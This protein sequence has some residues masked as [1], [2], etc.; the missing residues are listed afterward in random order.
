LKLRSITKCANMKMRFIRALAFAGQRRPAL[1]AKSSP[2]PGRRI[3]LGDL[4]LINDICVALEGHEDRDRR[5]AM[6]AATFAV[7]PH[8][9]FRLT[10]GHEAYG[11]TQAAAF[12]LI[13]H[14]A[15]LSASKFALHGI[16]D[17]RETRLPPVPLQC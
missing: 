3:E 16:K 13:A 14:A 10:R 2:S 17:P 12:E 5:P 4:T 6:L 11:A 15:E 1:G 8:H 7:A 9:R